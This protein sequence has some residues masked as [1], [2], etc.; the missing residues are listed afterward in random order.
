[1]KTDPYESLQNALAAAGLTGQ[2]RSE[3]Q[4]IVCSQAGPVWPNRGNSFW[5]SHKEGVWY[6]STWLPAGYRIPAT[7]DVLA[8]CLACM[9]VG[10]EAMYS[11]PPDIIARFGLQRID[12]GEYERLFPT[13]AAGD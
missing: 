8:L 13:E 5:L 2:R 11:V 9:A 10:T 6:L 12:D 7:Q 4:L 1:M 3:D